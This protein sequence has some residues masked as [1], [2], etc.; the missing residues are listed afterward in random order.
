MVYQL[1]LRAPA[2][3]VRFRGRR[4][5]DMSIEQ[6]E[7]ARKECVMAH[8]KV[9]VE[10]GTDIEIYYEDHGSGRPV[11]LIHGYPLNGRSWER[12]QRELLAAGY[13]AIYYHPGGLGLSRAPTN[14]YD[15]VKLAP[16]PVVLL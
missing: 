6:E 16:Y 7:T 8:L 2:E 1:E 12:Q 14:G 13:R 10:N 5:G 11:I 3:R 9:G 4:L 15:Y